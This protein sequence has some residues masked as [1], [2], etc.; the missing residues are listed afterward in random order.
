MFSR[1]S[2][3]FL[4]SG[5]LYAFKCN[6]INKSEFERIRKF[7]EKNFEIFLSRKEIKYLSFFFMNDLCNQLELSTYK[8]FEKKNSQLRKN[9]K[10]EIEDLIFKD[11]KTKKIYIYLKN[12]NIFSIITKNCK[13]F[14]S[15]N[16]LISRKIYNA[17]INIKKYINHEKNQIFLVNQ[18]SKYIESNR[19]Y[20]Y[21]KIISK[22]NLFFNFGDI[23]KFF[24]K[25]FLIKFK[26]KIHV[27]EY[28]MIYFKNHKIIVRTRIISKLNIKFNNL[29]SINKVGYFSPTSF[30]L[31]NEIVY[32]ELK[33]K[34]KLIKQKFNILEFYEYI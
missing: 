8:G 4:L 22:F 12:P 31:M 15:K 17:N 23:F 29:K 5:F 9:N 18:Y 34:K 10:F 11:F 26:K 3:V 2:R 13:Y 21:S 16:L 25:F 27:K 19:L 32:S 33:N 30:V 6:L 28:K 14:F 20:Y 24:G 1:S 7:Y